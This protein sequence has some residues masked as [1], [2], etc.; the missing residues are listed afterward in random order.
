M[1]R[2]NILLEQAHALLNTLITDQDI[3]VDATMGNG[4][5]TFFLSGIAKEVYAFDIQK[6][7]LEETKRKVGN[8]DHVHLVLDSHENMLSYV[9][10]FKGV[11]FNLG[12]LPRGD[13]S[14]TTKTDTTINTLEK[15]LPVLKKDG[16]IQIVVYPGHE[17]GQK[18]SD[19]LEVFT[20]KLP[21]YQYQVIT[22]RFLYTE[23]KPPYLIMIYKTK[24]E[25]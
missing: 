25:S 22:S 20:K 6:E 18:E 14:I 2:K 23:N 16:F 10:S 5:D 13:Q 1:M 9:S 17:E 12:Y 4:H 24:D 8:L 7:A 11:V 21:V 19:A 15:I 3:V